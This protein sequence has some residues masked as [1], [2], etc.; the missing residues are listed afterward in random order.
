MQEGSLPGLPEGW[1]Y[2]ADWRD[3]VLALGG[4][5]SV[6]LLAVWWQQQT[7]YWYRIAILT[8]L[9]AFVLS[10]TSIYLFWVPPYYAGCAA[11]CTGWRGF[12]LAVARVTFAGQTQ[13]GLIDFLL[14]TLLLWLIVLLATLIGRL[15]G[16]AIGWE[17][18]SRRVRLLVLILLFIV[19]W[20]LLPRFLD[21]PQPVTSGEELRLVTNAR[22]AAE[23]TYRITG[24]W[25]QRLA[26]EDVRQLSPNP[27]SEATP[28]LSAV[29]SQ[30]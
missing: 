12:P 19:P 9:G 5:L 13:I 24:L 18:R 30:V 26:L 17:N 20:A 11:G 3:L 28:D 22:R 8:F 7:R 15:V 27:L 2:F 1:A 14:N 6:A 4:L 16:V 23:S 25:V 10:F 29:R 21:P